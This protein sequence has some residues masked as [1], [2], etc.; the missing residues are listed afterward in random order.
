[1]SR[2]ARP[3][4]PS[5]REVSFAIIVAALTLVALGVLILLEWMLRLAFDVDAPTSIAGVTYGHNMDIRERISKHD[6]LQAFEAQQSRELQLKYTVRI[7]T[8]KRD[9]LLKKVVEHYYTCPEVHS[10]QVVWSELDRSPPRPSFFRLRAASKRASVHQFPVTGGQ[11]KLEFEIH[12]ENSLNNRFRPVLSI[13]TEAVFSVDDDL[14]IPCSLLQFTH[15]VWRSAPESMVGFMPRMHGF[16]DATQRYTYHEWW[17]VWRHGL[18]SFILTK[19]C[20]LHRSFLYRYAGMDDV[21]RAVGPA[22]SPLINGS[23]TATRIMGGSADLMAAKM[24]RKGRPSGV[25]GTSSD[26]KSRSRALRYRRRHRRLQT[27]SPGLPDEGV[28]AAKVGE[29]VG[30]G[31][32]RGSRRTEADPHSEAVVTGAAA[33]KDRDSK[34]RFVGSQPP[35]KTTTT[36]A[37]TPLAPLHHPL[38]VDPS[39]FIYS[40]LSPLT[41]ARLHFFT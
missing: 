4:W 37:R 28:T 20:F 1:M 29:T 11:P 24:Q 22:R 39:Q 27:L 30:E 9:D 31:W 36:R 14:M 6:D 18:Y 8:F 10:I 34:R 21:S 40:V 13:D 19:A 35:P 3:K 5:R 38:R 16:D 12:T 26:N 15:G 33:K 25:G 23:A 2:L 17:Y 41:H 7:N 32:M